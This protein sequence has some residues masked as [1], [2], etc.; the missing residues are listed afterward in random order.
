MLK[1]LYTSFYL[2]NVKE[3]NNNVEKK[4]ETIKNALAKP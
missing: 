2:N 1:F 3:K 4:T